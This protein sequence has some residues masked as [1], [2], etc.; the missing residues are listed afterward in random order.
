M[1][2]FCNADIQ[3]GKRKQQ[4]GSSRE[5][6]YLYLPSVKKLVSLNQ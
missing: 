4:L 1:T 3:V 6:A 5:F 2:H